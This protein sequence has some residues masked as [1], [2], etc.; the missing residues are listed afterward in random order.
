MLPMIHAL[1]VFVLIL[2]AVVALPGIRI[3]R[4]LNIDLLADDGLKSV[5]PCISNWSDVDNPIHPLVDVEYRLLKLLGT[6]SPLDCAL[7]AKLLPG[8]LPAV[9]EAGPEVALI[10]LDRTPYQ[11]DAALLICPYA[12]PY[13]QQEA[14]DSPVVNLNSPCY[15]VVGEIQLEPM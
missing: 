9:P 6:P 15:V 10:D 5:L 13:P 12:L 3:D 8:R 1:V 14:V 7:L 4:G 2:K 11:S